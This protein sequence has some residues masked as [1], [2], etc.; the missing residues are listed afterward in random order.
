MGNTKEQQSLRMSE[1]KLRELTSVSFASD[2]QS[3]GLLFQIFKCKN[4]F[5][6]YLKIIVSLN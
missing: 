4:S 3:F 5:E 6:N 1:V 2:P